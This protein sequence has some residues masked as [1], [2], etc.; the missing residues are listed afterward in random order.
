ML[1]KQFPPILLLVF[2][3]LTQTNAW[4]I[5]IPMLK[6]KVVTAQRQY[7]QTTAKKEEQSEKISNTQDNENT[8]Y[9]LPLISWQEFRTINE[10]T[11]KE[12]ETFAPLY[13]QFLDLISAKKGT[14]AVSALQG[15]P[16]YAQVTTNARYIF[17]GEDHSEPAIQHEIE[18]LIRTVR[19][20][21][22]NARILL[23][24][25]FLRTPELH[26]DPLRRA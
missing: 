3:L 19:Y 22:P 25:E 12:N 8:W 20:T 18:E 2:C 21:N 10:E 11:K 15:T 5:S 1:K 4:A 13:N 6:R 14:L 7:T 9:G 24:S 23:A 17:I 16:K 26:T